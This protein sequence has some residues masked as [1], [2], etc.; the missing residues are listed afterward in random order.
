MLIMAMMLLGELHKLF[1]RRLNGHVAQVFVAPMA[2]HLR[3]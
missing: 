2:L 1:I 3:R